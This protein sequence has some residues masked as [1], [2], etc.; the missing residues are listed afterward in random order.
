MYIGEHNFNNK[1]K[2]YIMGILNI[3]PDSFSDGGM[4]NDLEKAL[5]RV[6]DM[7]D[8]G[9]SI[10]DVGGIS[11]RPGYT[12]ISIEEEIARILPILKAIKEHFDVAISLDTYRSKVV[13]AAAPYIDMVN[14]VYGFKYDLNMAKTIHKHNL[15]VCIV[16][17]NK[18]N[19]NDDIGRDDS[20]AYIKKVIQEL[21]GSIEVALKS[22]IPKN[23]IMIDGGVG[24]GKDHVQNL[25]VIHYTAELVDIGYPVLIA[26]SNKG[27][28]REITG[29]I[30]PNRSH[31][32]VTSTI[33]GA[34]KGAQF[35]R[36]HDVEANKRALD[37]YEAISTCS[38]PCKY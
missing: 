1:K 29:N 33:F 25:M 12:E 35:F 14:D 21:L 13:E 34:F 16:A 11:T 7:I 38:M 20:N 27:F 2:Y 8:K 3:T 26:T 6:E 17:N 9:A 22:G 15:S 32:T 28:M 37:M 36:V 5:A 19:T 24:F 23:K 18:Y 31:E 4:Y 10:I 30:N